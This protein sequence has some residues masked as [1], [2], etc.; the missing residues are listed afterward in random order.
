[1]LSFREARLGAAK[2]S[3]EKSVSNVTVNK[4]IRNAEKILLAQVQRF[5]FRLMDTSIM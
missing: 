4:L 3:L 1:M 5:Q 2:Y